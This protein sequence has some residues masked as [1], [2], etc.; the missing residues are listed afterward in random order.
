MNE[1][2]ADVL[3][4][5]FLLL[6]K[7]FANY[8]GAFLMRSVC[9]LSNMRSMTQVAFVAPYKSL[10]SLTHRRMTFAHCRSISWIADTIKHRTQVRDRLE[11]EWCKIEGADAKGVNG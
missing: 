1:L 8:L 3:R 6:R 11:S 2:L 7:N 4:H 9:A 5:E 10:C